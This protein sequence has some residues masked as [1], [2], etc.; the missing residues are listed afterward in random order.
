LFKIA[1]LISGN[2]SN[3]QS[4]IDNINKGNLNCKIEA[5]ISDK[6]GVY[7]LERAKV[8]N[9]KTFS[10]DRRVYGPNVSD[11]I[12]KVTQGKVDFIVLAGFLSVLTGNVLKVFKDKIINIH[13]ALIP[14]FCGNKMYGLKVHEKALEYGVKVSGCT[15]HFVDEGT[16]TGPILLQRIVPVLFS[17]TAKDL[18]L[19][20]LTKEHE[21]LSEALNLIIAGKV[22]IV[23]RKVEI[24]GE[25][26]VL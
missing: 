8:N 20:V 5:V 23:G 21:A 3:L 18:Q 6:D 9:I 4:I 15:V 10:F 2:G 13:P 16:D 14:S 24:K 17:D 11:E 25:E 12:L 26:G 7:G 22:R 1:V 19:R